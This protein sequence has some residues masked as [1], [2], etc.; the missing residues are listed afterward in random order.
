MDAEI[1]EV[2]R[3]CSS[4]QVTSPSPPVAQHHP[5]EWQSQPWSRLYIDFVK[6]LLGHMSH[7]KWLDVHIMQS[8][9]ISKTMVKKLR[10]VFTTHGPRTIVSDNRPSFTN[11]EFKKF[12]QAN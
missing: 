1:E 2:I 3:N 5:W 7:S 11:D 6:P 10:F 8:I 4:C 9:S 12:I